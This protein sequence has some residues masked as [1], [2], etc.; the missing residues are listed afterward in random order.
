SIQQTP[1]G[2]YL[3]SG[4]T[5]SYGNLDGDFYLVKTDAS[6]NVQWEKTYGRAGLQECHYAQ[7]TPDGGCI[8]VGD[9]DDLSNGLGDTDVWLI[10]T[11]SVGN[12]VWEKVFGG[13]KKDGGKTV[14]NTSDGGFIIAGITRSFGLVNPNYFLIKAD[15]NG[16][17]QWQKTNYGTQKHDHAYRAIET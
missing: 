16:T 5:Y 1:D 14:E 7:A 4:Q 8:L 6:G 3:I 15:Y 11:D 17:L 12:I 13:T 9:A 10:K 2:G